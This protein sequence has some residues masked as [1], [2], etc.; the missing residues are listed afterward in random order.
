MDSALSKTIAERYEEYK[1]HRRSDA[2]LSA[3]ARIGEIDNCIKNL[4]V[5]RN[6]RAEWEAILSDEL[7]DDKD[8]Q[9]IFQQIENRLFQ[10]KKILAVGGLLY[11][12]ALLIITF[13]VEIDM[14][15]NF[16]AARGIDISRL[17]TDQTDAMIMEAVGARESQH[18]F[19]EAMLNA[20]RNWGIPL[21]N[22][23]LGD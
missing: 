21:T 8:I 5:R 9:K 2:L 13:R 23:W 15:I 22:R 16:L 4:S 6:I 17:S 7:I 18:L 19:K 14:A 20:K 1:D 3:F 11:E 10:V 12:E